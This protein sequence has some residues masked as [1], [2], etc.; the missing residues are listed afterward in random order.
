[1]PKVISGFASNRFICLCEDEKCDH[2]KTLPDSEDLANL[3][4]MLAEWF[5]FHLECKNKTLISKPNTLKNVYRLTFLN[6]TKHLFHQSEQ[7]VT[8]RLLTLGHIIYV[9]KA[10]EDIQWCDFIEWSIE[11]Q[12]WSLIE[13]KSN[14]E[15]PLFIKGELNRLGV[16]TS[17]SISQYLTRGK[18]LENKSLEIGFR[19]IKL[20]YDGILNYNMSRSLFELFYN[21]ETITNRIKID[22]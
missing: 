11:K 22:S 18:Q 4:T 1:M 5:T 2:K 15:E 8:L 19:S 10:K 7:E 14:S 12:Q 17:S 6:Y 16:H 3:K 21:S 13:L 20:Y 9:A